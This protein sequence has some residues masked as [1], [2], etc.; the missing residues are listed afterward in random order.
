ML[1]LTTILNDAR[2]AQAVF[3]HYSQE[4]LDACAR[5]AGKALYD[6]AQEL[7][8]DAV[9]ET[10]MGNVADKTLKNQSKSRN[11][12][13]YLKGK[14]STGIIERDETNS[15]ITI[16]HPAGVVGAVTPTTS[17][18][19]TIMCNVMCALKGGNAIV[20][21]PHPRA[22]KVSAKTV[23]IINAELDKLE[24]PKKLVQCIEQPSMQLTSE[25][26]ASVDVL[27]A[28]GGPA[29]VKSAYSSGKPSF[30]V[31]AGNVQTIFDVD[32]DYQVAAQKVI[33]GR[34]F[35]NGIICSGDQS[36]II[37]QTHYQQVIDAFTSQGAYY[38]ED[39]R[40]ADKLRDALF[41]DGYTNPDL[42]GQNVQVIAQ[43]AGLDVPKAAKLI[44]VKS[45]GR[46]DD[47]LRSEKMCP[48]LSAFAYK[49]LH[50]AISIAKTNL[51]VRGKGHTCVIHSNTLEHIEKI[52]A[53]LP[54]SRIAIN[55]AGSLS[56]G[57]TLQN[58][59]V[60]TGTLGCGFWGNNSTSE[61]LNYQHMLNVQRIGFTM[62]DKSVPSDA[63]IWA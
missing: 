5:A 44:V 33:A 53:A 15:M 16:A 20:I 51:E 28:T 10:G 29:M 59:F 6:N 37:P 13:H 60:P 34:C 18:S 49:D 36:I 9:N 41:K 63:E 2:A 39:Q 17:P 30:G 23:S 38:I 58:G 19:M 56:V 50:Q 27:V 46:D 32:V 21:A 35:D 62:S 25:L 12:W 14:K 22:K 52:G 42:I 45:N 47:V 54:V 7:A 48:V 26:M 24:A 1:T 57:G 3:A 61:N 8:E 4:Q 43:H 11:V 55:E 31:G 40:E